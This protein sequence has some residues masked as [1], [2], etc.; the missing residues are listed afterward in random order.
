M[1]VTRSSLSTRQ[2]ENEVLRYSR[3]RTELKQRDGLIFDASPGSTLESVPVSRQWVESS[4][5]RI[6]QSASAE[7]YLSPRARIINERRKHLGS[8]LSALFGYVNS[9]YGTPVD[10]LQQL[11]S[12]GCFKSGSIESSEDGS[13]FVILFP[14]EANITL[15]TPTHSVNISTTSFPL[16]LGSIESSLVSSMISPGR[17][18][19]ENS[20]GQLKDETHKFSVPN[21]RLQF[22]SHFEGGNLQQA[23]EM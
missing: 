3:R 21:Y 6:D 1:V 13:G 7:I 2:V 16:K 10:Q 12:S 23:T 4:S 11:S 20:R 17:C 9:K 8:E 5:T 19:L 18:N 14:P 15:P 22:E